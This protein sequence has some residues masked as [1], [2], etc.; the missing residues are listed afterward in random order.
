MLNTQK[1]QHQLSR[2]ALPIVLDSSTPHTQR[3]LQPGSTTFQ[4]APG[5][6][7]VEHAHA[8]E[9]GDVLKGASDAAQRRIMGMHAS[10]GMAVET[11]RPLLRLIHAIDDVEQRALA[12]TI[13]TDQCADFPFGHGKA[14]VADGFDTFE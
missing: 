4:V 13:G 3:L 8:L 11:D 5:E 6:H 9:Q 1:R 14:D 2:F 10:P 7:V 12:R